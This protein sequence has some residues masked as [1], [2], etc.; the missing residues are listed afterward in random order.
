MM[1]ETA[2]KVKKIKSDTEQVIITDDDFFRIAVSLEKKHALF[3]KVWEMGIPR[4]TREIDT[5]AVAF[6]KN[7][8][9]I[10]F[11]FNP[12][13]WKKS[14]DYNKAFLVSHE[15]L[16]V[17]LNHGARMKSALERK[18]NM[19][20]INMAA[21]IVVNHALVEKF[22][23]SRKKID[24]AENYCWVDTVFGEKGATGQTKKWLENQGAQFKKGEK[25]TIPDDDKAFEYYFKL[26][27]QKSEQFT[28]AAKD[29]GIQIPGGSGGD[30]SGLMGEPQTVDDHGPMSKSGSSEEIC[31]ELSERLGDE[32]KN[33]IKETIDKHYQHEKKDGDKEGEDGQDKQGGGR[34]AGTGGGGA[35]VFV[36]PKLL[37]VKKKK[38]W[39][40]II[41]KWAQKYMRNDFRDVEQ[42]ARK[43]RRMTM[44][45]SGNM[46]LPCEMEVE[47]MYEDMEKIKVF[48]F[49]DTSGSCAGYKE[50]FY[51]AANSLP[52]ERFDLRC[53]CFDTSV[54]EMEL[55][56]NKMFNGGGTYFHIIEEKIQAIVAKEKIKYPKAVFVLTDGYGDSV[57]PSMPERWFWF[58]TDGSMGYG[59]TVPKD[60]KK[61]NLKDFE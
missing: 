1:S 17:S 50:R 56:D 51:K 61:F 27:K 5:A 28:Q 26:L 15:A 29:N 3:Y 6:D 38:K 4:V 40:T 37:K 39:E 60:C 34:Q 45:E 19:Q 12:D 25:E 21:D 9:K 10:D 35:W 33:D 20:L 43:H 23:F 8:T 31:K 52:P 32:E 53:F 55:K 36:D 46:F 49:M 16:H 59:V 18:E 22:G 14:D 54:K 48:F 13:L 47:D 42:W 44:L 7:G 11:M 24:N 58:L 41:K 30:G 57:S 2:E